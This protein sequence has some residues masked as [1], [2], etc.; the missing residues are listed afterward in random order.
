MAEPEKLQSIPEDLLIDNPTIFLKKVA[1]F[2]SAGP[3]GIHAVFD[4][5]RTL[6]VK[7]PGSHDEVTNQRIQAKSKKLSVD[8]TPSLRQDRYC[9]CAIYSE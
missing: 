5:D 2:A 4:F 3:T 7:K 6:T 9:L 1:N 8:S